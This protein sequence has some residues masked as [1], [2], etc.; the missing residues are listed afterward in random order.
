MGFVSRLLSK[1]L[2]AAN[3]PKDHEL[4]DFPDGLLFSFNRVHEHLKLTR[5][6]L[7]TVAER[8]NQKINALAAQLGTAEEDSTRQK[9]L[10]ILLNTTMLKR[11]IVA[12]A[13]VALDKFLYSDEQE[14]QHFLDIYGSLGNFFDKYITATIDPQ[15]SASKLPAFHRDLCDL[16]SGLG[17]TPPPDLLDADPSFLKESDG[18]NVASPSSSESTYREASERAQ[19]A[20]RDLGARAITENSTA[21]AEFSSLTALAVDIG[22]AAKAANDKGDHEQA[23]KLIERLQQIKQELLTLNTDN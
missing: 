1:R 2:Y 21:L 23:G 22:K 17:L 19:R 11:E 4:E 12:S 14:N 7:K 18:I 6:F 13:A 10:K 15:V 20:A 8:E 16:T 5:H 3:N 9:K